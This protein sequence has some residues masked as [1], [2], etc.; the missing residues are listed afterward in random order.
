MKNALLN[1]IEESLNELLNL[2]FNNEILEDEL[3]KILNETVHYNQIH[4]LYIYEMLF[5]QALK[6]DKIPKSTLLLNLLFKN[7]D[8][9][10]FIYPDKIQGCNEKDEDS[11]SPFPRTKLFKGTRLKVL[12]KLNLN[13]IRELYI[14]FLYENE[15]EIPKDGKKTVTFKVIQDAINKDLN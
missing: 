1:A 15:E 2:F 9:D 10:Y 3:L 11:T 5:I 13:K 14:K 4:Q 8:K 12:E 7:S 6:T